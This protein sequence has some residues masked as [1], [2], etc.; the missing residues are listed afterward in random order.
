MPAI[1]TDD[2]IL[3]E[4]A[5]TDA[6]AA[7]IDA[8]MSEMSAA[9]KLAPGTLAAW[10]AFVSGYRGWS[11][12]TAQRVSGGFWSGAWFGVPELGNQAAAY[13]ATMNAWQAQINSAAGVQVAPVGTTPNQAA[14]A[15]LSVPGLN[16]PGGGGFSTG[17]LVGVAALAVLLVAV[18]RR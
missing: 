2:D 15:N 3:A 12:F 4:L 5:R 1:V 16:A 13:E 14:D 7:S 6:L 11:T 8:Q 17:L 18:G 9:G 10:Q